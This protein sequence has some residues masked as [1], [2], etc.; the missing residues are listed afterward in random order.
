MESG[1]RKV[2]YEGG[3]RKCMVVREGT[4]TEELLK[5]VRKMTGS[6]MSEEKL[7]YS[8]KYDR[9]MLVAVEVDNDVE[10]I[11]KGND[12][13]EHRSGKARTCEG[14]RIRGKRASYR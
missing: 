4:G 9:E 10:V 13:R 5:M 7:W 8:L 3:S 6:D 12:E 11:F 2:T 14:C 1:D